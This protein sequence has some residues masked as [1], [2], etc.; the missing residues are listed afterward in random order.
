MLRASTR[1]CRSRLPRVLPSRI[2]FHLP[3]RT[4]RVPV[5]R[6][7]VMISGNSDGSKLHVTSPDL[8]NDVSLLSSLSLF[9]FFCSLSASSGG[10]S[11][12][13]PIASYPSLRK[14][15]ALKFHQPRGT[16]QPARW[17]LSIWLFMHP[18]APISLSLLPLP[19]SACEPHFKRTTLRLLFPS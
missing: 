4:A 10:E 5:G 2:P 15:I 7:D 19:G 16:C 8:S 11:R 6:R 3:C 18:S 17:A 9:G 1:R 13:S 12:N 14:R